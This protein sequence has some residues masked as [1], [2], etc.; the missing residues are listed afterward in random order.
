MRAALEVRR[1][2][3]VFLIMAT[4]VSLVSLCA[5]LHAAALGGVRCGQRWVSKKD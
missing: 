4:G 1:I 5:P 3:V 2:I